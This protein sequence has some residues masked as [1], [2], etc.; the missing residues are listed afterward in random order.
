ML[1]PAS[2]TPWSKFAAL[3]EADFYLNTARPRRAAQ[4]MVW[5]GRLHSK[6]WSRCVGGRQGAGVLPGYTHSTKSSKFFLLVTVALTGKMQGSNKRQTRETL[7]A[8]AL[9]PVLLGW[10]WGKEGNVLPCKRCFLWIPFSPQFSSVLCLVS[11]FA[12]WTEQT[13]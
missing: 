6:T 5:G 10:L 2:C 4:R 7:P 8:S 11:G 1:T 3:S 12:D 9:C 13:K